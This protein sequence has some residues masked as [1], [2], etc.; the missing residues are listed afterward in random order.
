MK[1]E[2]IRLNF[3]K[4]L[5]TLRKSRGLSQV[6]LA[7][8]LNYT[9]KAVSKWEKNETI[10]D[11]TSLSAIAEYFDITVD[12]LISSRNVV[13]KSNRKKNRVRIILSSIG[14]CFFVCAFI[15]LFLALYNIPKSY[16]AIPF[17][18]FT[19]GIVL[20][21]FTSL[22]FRRLYIYLGIS[23]TI[24]SAAIITMIFMDFNLFWIVLI[25][26][27]IVDVAFFPF[28]RVVIPKVRKNHI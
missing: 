4:N 11:I 22:W 12:D 9:D 5:L 25:I 19:S 18:F 26:A 10:P 7:E 17:A 20:I 3:S 21:V 27:A 15:Y 23:L 8:A 16:V 14:I 24:W 28:L 6:Q 2:E 1:E 13:K